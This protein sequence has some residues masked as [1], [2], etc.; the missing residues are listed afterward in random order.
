MVDDDAGG[1]VGTT[2]PDSM[3]EALFGPRRSPAG[4]AMSPLAKLGA[5][6]DGKW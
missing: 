4:S 6:K 3:D 5:L 1:V 2:K